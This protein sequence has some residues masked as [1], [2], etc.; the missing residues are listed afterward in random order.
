MALAEIEKGFDHLRAGD[1]PGAPRRCG[2]LFQMFPEFHLK[3][4]KVIN[5][6]H[7]KV[8][9]NQAAKLIPGRIFRL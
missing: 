7:R 2:H 5:E 3:L 9:G 6:R 1:F 8:F 4:G